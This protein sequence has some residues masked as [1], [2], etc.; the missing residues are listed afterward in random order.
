V[1]RPSRGDTPPPYVL[2]VDENGVGPRLGPMIVTSVLVRT[3]ARGAKTMC[4]PARGKLAERAGDSKALVAFADATLGEAW[5]RAIVARQGGAPETQREL[6]RALFL[7]PEEELTR[8]CPT[9]HDDLCFSD[10]NEALTADAALVKE[11]A[12]DLER[13]A[14]RGAD[15]TRARVAVSCARRLNDAAALGRSRF[16]VDLEHMERLVL[17]ARRDAGEDVLALCGKVGGID[18][19]G[20]R[21]IH[22][23][24]YLFSTIEEGRAAS[25]YQIPGVGRVAFTRDADAHHLVVGLASLVGKWVRDALMRRVTGWFRELDPD[26]AD[27]SGYHD[28]ATARFVDATRL[29]RRAR[30]VDDDCFERRCAEPRV[31]SAQKKP[32]RPARPDGGPQRPSR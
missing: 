22:L 30:K 21:F 13:L 4:A 31:T 19:Y 14:A 3:D 2:G 18:F 10:R 5:A 6:M 23:S 32:K 8:P 1:T 24:S 15:V 29:V 17:A 12:R 7:D 25:A 16:D 26:V 28:P 9:H 27:V 20:G 11:C